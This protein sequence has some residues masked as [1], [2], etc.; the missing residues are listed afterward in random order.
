MF[1]CLFINALFINVDVS[2]ITACVVCSVCLLV[3]S[4][5]EGV[6]VAIATEQLLDVLA[7]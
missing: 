6:F 2:I 1:I 7:T 3:Y 5:P 4:L